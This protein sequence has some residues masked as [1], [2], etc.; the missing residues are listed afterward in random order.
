MIHT[1]YS[2]RFRL[3]PEEQ[4]LAYRRKAN[5]MQRLQVQNLALAAELGMLARVRDIRRKQKRT[6]QSRRK[7]DEEMISRINA[8][9]LM[10]VYEKRAKEGACD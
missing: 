6:C 5:T 10:R 1:R 4:E 8:V 7:Y 9:K 2:S 3:T